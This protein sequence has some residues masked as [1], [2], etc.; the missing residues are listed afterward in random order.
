MSQVGYKTPDGVVRSID[1]GTPIEAI[2]IRPKRSKIKIITF[3]KNEFRFI[4]N[5]ELFNYNQI[6]YN[7]KG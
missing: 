7:L 3:K 6:C 4:C 5:L 2:K 1:F